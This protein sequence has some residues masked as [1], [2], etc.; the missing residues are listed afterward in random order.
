MDHSALGR[1]VQTGINI[2]FTL[3]GRGQH[4]AIARRDRGI[5]KCVVPVMLLGMDAALGDELRGENAGSPYCQ[6]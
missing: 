1:G 6:P 4:I 3:E 2:I 5:G